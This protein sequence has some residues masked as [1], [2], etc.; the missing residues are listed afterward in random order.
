MFRR[1]F[2]LNQ[3]EEKCYWKYWHADA[4]LLVFVIYIYSD[5]YFILF[6]I[7]ISIFFNEPLL[8]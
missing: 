6:L 7:S 1:A 8:R 5:P 3:N 2:I 4:Y